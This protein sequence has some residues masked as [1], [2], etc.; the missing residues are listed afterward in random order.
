MLLTPAETNAITDRLLSTSRAD[1][2]VVAINGGDRTNLRF[3]RNNAT[4]NGSLSALSVGITSTFGGRSGSVSVNGLE[5]E[6]L[7]QAQGRAE[8]IARLAPVNPE[9]MPPLG[10]QSYA[11]G[12]GYDE[13]SANKRAGHLAVGAKTV[14]EQAV[15]RNINAA[16]YGETSRGFS[17]IATSAG[18][19][20]YD[21]STQSRFAITARNEAG[22]WSGWAGGLETRF[23]RLDIAALGARA[24]DKAAYDV[25]P[26]DLDPGKYTVILEPS[27]V[28]DLVSY[29][30]WNLDARS[31]D[32]GRS[33]LAKKGGGTKLGEKLFHETVT[34]TSDP[35][36]PIVPE[37]V[38]GVDGLP[39]KRTAWVEAGVVRN[40]AY[41]RFWA[42]KMGREPQP[43]SQT[44]V[45]R[46]GPTSIADMIKDTKRGVLV[47]RLWYIR[48]VDPQTLLLTG[49]TRDGNFLI[50]NGRIAAPARNFRFNESPVAMLSN[51]VAMGP[52]ERTHGGEVDGAAFAAPPLLV[53][54]FTFS[55][56]SSG[57]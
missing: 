2:C 48:D 15:A 6:A 27:A 32:E 26:V 44:F 23:D 33:F 7:T 8:E 57:I 51:I 20:A 17:A 56:K 52:S 9:Y 34:I 5:G 21:R 41:S 14:I 47:T 37:P 54:D 31:A 49:L 16:G 12:M 11:A 40:L 55:S 3:A 35:E 24:I 38:Y 18:L 43:Q 53:K 46:G 39:Q 19:F 10:P 45:M 30:L 42:Q 4:T 13:S 29:L 28:A 50:E 22:T 1:S 36:D 25:A